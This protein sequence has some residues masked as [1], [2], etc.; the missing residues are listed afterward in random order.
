VSTSVR[1]PPCANMLHCLSAAP[2]EVYLHTFFFVVMFSP[3]Q[4]KRGP[5]PSASLHLSQ[6]A[7]ITREATI[8]IIII[9]IIIIIIIIII[10]VLQHFVKHW[11]PFQ[12]LDS[13]HI[14]SDSFDGRSAHRK[15][16]TYTQNTNRINAHST[17][18]HALSRIR[19]HD[20]SVRSSEDSSC[21]R[22]RGHCDRLRSYNVVEKAW[23]RLN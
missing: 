4:S 23:A 2:L 18:I 20:P 10:M 16:S 17:D 9:F 21:L 11:T 6:I 13:M 7:V 12:F 5:L 3:L 15:A 1:Y 22:P 19:T 8:I 14:L